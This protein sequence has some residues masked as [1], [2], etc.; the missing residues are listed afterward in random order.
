VQENNEKLHKIYGQIVL[1]ID[2]ICANVACTLYGCGVQIFCQEFFY[3]K[4]YNKQK[5]LVKQ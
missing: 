3:V 5:L 4:I 2:E 1:K